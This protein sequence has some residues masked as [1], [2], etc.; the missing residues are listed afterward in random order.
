MPDHKVGGDMVRRALGY[1]LG[2]YLLMAVIGRFVEGMGAVRCGCAA[3]CWCKRPILSTFRW[4]F[5]WGH[6]GPAE[7]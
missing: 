4:V 1:V 7:G 6:R 5:P 3:D 2:F